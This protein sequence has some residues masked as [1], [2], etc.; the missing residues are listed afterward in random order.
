MAAELVLCRQKNLP[1]YFRFVRFES[2]SDGLQSPREVTELCA[3][4]FASLRL[5]QERIERLNQIGKIDAAYN[6]IPFAIRTEC[7]FDLFIDLAPETELGKRLHQLD[8]VKPIQYARPLLDIDRLR[9][10]DLIGN[11]EQ[12]FTEL[13]KIFFLIW[14]HSWTP[15]QYFGAESL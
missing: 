6:L 7:V 3:V 12:Q 2:V 11:A 8:A 4:V 14:L 9:V 1:T 15:L 10:E 13:G 5:L